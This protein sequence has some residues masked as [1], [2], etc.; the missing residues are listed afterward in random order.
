MAGVLCITAFADDT[1]AADTVL[2]VSAQMKGGTTKILK[3]FNNFEE[4]WNYAM[5]LA[6]DEDVM[7]T[8]KYDRIVVDL[9]AD[10]TATNN[11]F[12]EDDDVG[13]ED[14]TI[15]FQD[16][17]K[18]TLN[19]N[20]HVID[21]KLTTFW[22]DG[23][24]MYIDS[25]ADVIINNG[26]I[27]GGYSDNGAG[28]IHIKKNANVT[29]NNVNIVGNKTYDDDG[30]GIA[31]YGGSTLTMNG[32]SFKDNLIGGVIT[33]YGGAIYIDDATATFNGVEFKNNQGADKNH[34]GATIYANESKVTMNACVVDG[35]GNKDTAKG[36]TAPVSIIHAIDTTVY[37]KGSTFT[38]NG[39]LYI[40]QST[41]VYGE[42]NVTEKS[43]ILYLD[44]ST[45][46]IEGDCTF[47]NNKAYSVISAKDDDKLYISNSRFTDNAANVLSSGDHSDNSYFRN[48]VFNNNASPDEKHS[49]TFNI[50]ENVLTFYDCELGNSTFDKSDEDYFR[51]AYSGV[52]QDAA[53]LAVKALLADGTV[54]E[55][56]Y[57]GDFKGGWNS[58][59]DLAL[60]GDY[61]RIVVDLYA[62]WTAPEGDF[63]AA[64][65][66]F[67]GN[68]IRVPDNAHVTI[69]GNGKTINRGLEDNKEDG[70]VMYIGT[71]ADVIINDATITGG[72]SLDGAGGIHIEDN[73]K[74]VLN[75]VNVIKNQSYG[76]DGSAIAVYSG[77]VLVMNGGSISDNKMRLANYLLI[78]LYPHGTLYTYEATATLNNVT[79]SNNSAS[80]EDP[81]GVAIY[82][83]E[84]T[85]TLN[86]CVISGNST[87][88]VGA[89][90]EN[91]IS[92]IDSTLI[93]NN[94][95]I[96]NNSAPSASLDMTSTTHLFYVKNS[97]LAFEGG[98]IT[99]NKAD[100]LFYLDDSKADFNGTTITDNVSAT[101]DIDNGTEK[102]TL[103]KCTLGNNNPLYEDYDILMSNDG[104]LVINDCN[105]GDTTFEDEDMVIF[106]N[107]AT[108][109]I[110]GEGS[111][112]MIV[113]IVALV[114]AGAAIYV[115][116]SAKKKG[117]E[118]PVAEKNETEA[119]AASEANTAE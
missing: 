27:T 108:G 33:C 1:P 37:M 19:M 63:C 115:N 9:Y 76:S 116:V 107:K 80:A 82:A 113:A 61:D 71:G 10:W 6:D 90:P 67:R 75:N 21:R 14:N 119:D 100:T 5:G 94:T 41:G 89:L 31:M 64:G 55:T 25:D 72:Y 53:V 79:I 3:D 86:D 7:K 62:D 47:Q 102:V 65:N 18:F 118:A 40:D 92:V 2:R 12:A 83:D 58:A 114:A 4:G 28:G 93:V 78:Y 54:A 66:G 56:N 95:D 109:S 85:V 68:T 43:A 104:T 50:L 101:F 99:D 117:Y 69:N 106:S 23:E 26:T 91:I 24:V 42:T 59:M 87:E 48:C 32:G 38:N 110:F 52:T 88:N 39:A 51:F 17:V 74:V 44:D 77:A 16:G 29:L 49:Y 11:M 20:G 105:L 57:Y 111:I 60:T 98:N 34:H 84:S 30:A 8:N 96:T 103:T 36:F 15:Y 22:S 112:A 70:E 97:T 46:N 45:L 13:F 73:A 81:E 35:N